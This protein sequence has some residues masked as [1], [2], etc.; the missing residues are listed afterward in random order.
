[1]DAGRWISMLQA[2]TRDVTPKL[3]EVVT[4]LPLIVRGVLAKL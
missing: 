4:K 3:A 2:A 1:M